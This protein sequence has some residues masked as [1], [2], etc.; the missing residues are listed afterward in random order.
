MGI[1][2]QSVA[3]AKRVDKKGIPELTELVKSG[4]VAVSA[5]ARMADEPP[6][7]RK[8]VD[9]ARTQIKQGKS[10]ISVPYFV[11]LCQKLTISRRR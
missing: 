9:E 4:K 8:I 11:K 10:P 1:C 2:P 7:S 5:A 3:Y 6:E